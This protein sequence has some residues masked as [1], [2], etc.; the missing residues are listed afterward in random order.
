MHFALLK[1][2]L[3]LEATLMFA[4]LK[5]LIHEYTLNEYLNTCILKFHFLSFVLPNI[6]YFTPD[7]SNVLLLRE[8]RTGFLQNSPRNFVRRRQ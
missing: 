7:Y 8:N 2:F 6:L 4:S 3:K 5:K 1:C